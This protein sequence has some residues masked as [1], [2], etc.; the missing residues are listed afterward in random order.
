MVTYLR[1]L[2]MYTEG[3]IKMLTLRATYSS[4]I[5]IE[6][7]FNYEECK[8]AMDKLFVDFVLM[9]SKNSVIPYGILTSVSWIDESGV[10][11]F[12]GDKIIV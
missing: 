6:Q 7:S 3:G 4:N 9:V 1:E 12:H 10:T 8:E 5:I 2:L 11:L